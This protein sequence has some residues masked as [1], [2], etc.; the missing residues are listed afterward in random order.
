MQITY[1]YERTGDEEAYERSWA[2]VTTDDA[3]VDDA[4]AKGGKIIVAVRVRPLNAREKKMK[5]KVTLSTSTVQT[6]RSKKGTSGGGSASSGGQHTITMTHADSDE[7]KYFGF[8]WVFDAAA[9]SDSEHDASQAA[10]FEQLAIVDGC[11]L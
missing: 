10:V 5:A 8:D 11:L 2:R 1:Q 9:Q 4:Q 3:A 6:G 7:K